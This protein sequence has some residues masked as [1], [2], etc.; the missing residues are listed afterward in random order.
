M[1]KEELKNAMNIN[2]KLFT[3][4]YDP[5]RS[6]LVSFVFSLICALNPPFI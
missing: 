5:E 6:I 4:G 3:K 1:G 2:I